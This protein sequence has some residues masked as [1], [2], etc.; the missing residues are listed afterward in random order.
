MKKHDV[1]TREALLCAA[2][3]AT[4]GAL[5]FAVMR[6]GNE[7]A[8]TKSVPPT[9]GGNI[10]ATPRDQHVGHQSVAMSWDGGLRG[11]QAQAVA[12]VED[13]HHAHQSSTEPF[14]FETPA[15]EATASGAPTPNTNDPVTLCADLRAAIAAGRG[16]D[17]SSIRARL[18]ALGPNAV[19]AVS[20]L[21]RSGT[22]SVE[23]E[24]VRLLVQIGDTQGL[25]LALGK[26]LTVPRESPAYGLFLAAFADNRSPVVARW[27]TDT[28]GKAQYADTRERL[29]DLIYAMRGPAA[30]AA[31]EEAALKPADQ[32]HAQDSIDSIA[33]RHDPS[34]TDE[35]AALLGSEHQGIREAAALGLAEVGSDAACQVLAARADTD[36]ACANALAAVSTSYAQETLL[37]MVTD[38]T[39]TET[40]RTAAIQSLAGQSGGRVETILANACAQEQNL[41]VAAEMQAALAALA[42]ARP[43]PVNVDSAAPMI[44]T[45]D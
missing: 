8:Q 39:R 2:C 18:V 44:E 7:T 22:E 41:A 13:I 16:G 12:P 29:L 4:L 24:S 25:A 9:N 33:T 43:Q 36:P 10:A 28:L 30:V 21:L 6:G 19:P 40:V 11:V 38:R 23:I 14:G 34:E 45:C 26:L 37:A 20:G 1:T 42:T 5:L 35:L 3:V 15:T 32:M 17:I 31:L 27:L